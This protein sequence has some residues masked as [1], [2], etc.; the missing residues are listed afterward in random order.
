MHKNVKIV[1]DVDILV[2]ISYPQREISAFDPKRTL[3]IKI[4]VMA[5]K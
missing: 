1:N 5:R 3:I 4:L 2:L